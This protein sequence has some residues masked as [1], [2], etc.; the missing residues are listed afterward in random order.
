MAE[1]TDKQVYYVDVD[2]QGN[3]VTR[4]PKGR[5]RTRL[6]YI[7]CEDGNWR[8]DPKFDLGQ[9]KHVQRGSYRKPHFY[10]T[11]D[12]DGQEISR[13]PV[14]RGKPASGY[15]RREDGNFYMVIVPENTVNATANEVTGQTV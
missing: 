14:S 15:A 9:H 10:I 1:Q 11:L 2:S 3:E 7:E 12:K 13:K 4:L 6:G 8:K 5:G